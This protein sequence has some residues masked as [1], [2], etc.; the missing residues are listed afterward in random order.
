MSDKEQLSSGKKTNQQELQEQYLKS[1]DE[2]EV[3]Q[4]VTGT[5]VAVTQEY[6]FLDVGY[7]SEGKIP[8]EEFTDEPTIGESLEVVLINKEGK[9]G[10]VIV[11]KSKADAKK[12]WK[13]VKDAFQNHT[14]IEGK[15][16]RTVKGG[17]EVSLGGDTK[18]F[19]PIS[20]MDLFRIDDPEKYVGTKARFFIERLYNDNRVNIILS[21]RALLEQEVETN[22]DSFFENHKEGD[23]VK[24]S[25]KSFTSFGAFIDLG[26]FDGLLHIN[27]MSWGHVTRPKDI[28]KKGDELELRLVKMDLENKKINL[29]LK[30]MTDNPW[31]HFHDNYELDDVISGKVTKLTDFGAFIELEEG[32]E[33]LAHISELSWTKRIKHPKEILNIGDSV[34]AKILGFDLDE[35]KVSLGLKQIQDNPWDSISESFPVGMRL[36]KTVKKITNTGAFIELEDGID[37]FLHIDDL[38]WT[39]KYKN[40]GAV[41]KEGEEVEVQ[42]LN[43]DAENRNIRVGI[44]QL[45]DD[46][47]A[48]LKRA[49]PQGSI[50]EGEVTS[51]TDFGVFVK[52]QGD[53]EGLIS[54]NQLA[55]PRE[56]SID[57][58][59]KELEPGTKVKAVV[60]EIMPGKQK[61]SLSMRELKKQQERQEIEKYMSD[62]KEE[63][64]TFTLGDF[65]KNDEE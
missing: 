54:K 26:G 40:P 9:N 16:I 30:D 32:I 59:L 62:E 13:D 24:G 50:I 64:S 42:V 29:S 27:D 23:I 43:S 58:A 17:F 53:I 11:S 12:R 51:I 3:G 20:K 46:P 4:L 56:K 21:R 22:R 60:S 48:S 57:E 5:I 35:R 14:P 49:Y 34:D 28:V 6:V 2:L 52:V 31:E 37:A 45:S 61:L 47:W 36:T 15:V 41:L 63:E 65:L 8:T 44:K 55:D 1:L 33:G 7:K 10:E 38:S 18:G 19:N 25:V 39:K